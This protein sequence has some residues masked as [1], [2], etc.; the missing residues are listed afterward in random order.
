MNT[1]KKPCQVWR[2]WDGL[3]WKRWMR[4]AVQNT[5]NESHA[6]KLGELGD[7]DGVSRADACNLQREHHPELQVTTKRTIIEIKEESI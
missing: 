5:V 4:N 3:A 6:R 7:Q 2:S 1:V